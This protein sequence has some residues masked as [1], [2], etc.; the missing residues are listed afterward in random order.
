M[1]S[2]CILDTE[3]FYNSC[4]EHVKF[5]YIRKENLMKQNWK[6][7]EVHKI[8]TKVI[9]YKGDNKSFVKRWVI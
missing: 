4:Y 1:E 7:E 3:T 6:S 5:L 9:Y 8:Y 2:V